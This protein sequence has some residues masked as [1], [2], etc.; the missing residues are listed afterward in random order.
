M[1]AALFGL[2]PMPHSSNKG[3]LY[4]EL[5]CLLC[6]ES[7][8]A[9]ASWVQKLGRSQR[10]SRR[11][12]VRGSQWTVVLRRHAALRVHQLQVYRRE[13]NQC[14]FGVEM[15]VENHVCANA[16]FQCHTR[17]GG[18]PDLRPPNVGW[19]LRSR[20]QEVRGEHSG[21]LHH[22]GQA[23]RKATGAQPLGERSTQNAF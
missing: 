19:G 15:K 23:A 12:Q 7:V 2:K 20:V 9:A 14:A 21:V 4:G 17:H 16:V 13:V 11:I 5:Q 18:W 3:S 1:P 8:L 10:A 6:D 22:S